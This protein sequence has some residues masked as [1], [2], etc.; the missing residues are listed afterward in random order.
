[1][2]RI[3]FTAASSA[4]FFSPRPTQGAA[5][6]AAVSVTRMSSRAKLRSGIGGIIPDLLVHLVGI[7]ALQSLDNHDP[8]GKLD[9]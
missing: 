7:V 2:A 3:A 6:I 5:A 1:M 4:K 8:H 9:Q